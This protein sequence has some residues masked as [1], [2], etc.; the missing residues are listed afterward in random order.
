VVARGRR[1]RATTGSYY[2]LTRIL[3]AGSVQNRKTVV[4]M[5]RGI[6][7]FVVLPSTSVRG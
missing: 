4:K 1:F 7:D 2:V 6:A 3:I 5:H